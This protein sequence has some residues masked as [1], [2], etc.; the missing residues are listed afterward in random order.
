MKCLDGKHQ[1]RLPDIVEIELRMGKKSG[2][3]I[4]TFTSKHEFLDIAKGQ[5][6]SNDNA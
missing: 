4:I 5:A 2:K 3:S 6:L 1:N